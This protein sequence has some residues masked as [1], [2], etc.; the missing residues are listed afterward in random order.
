MV[1]VIREKVDA[2]LLPQ[3]NP[4]KLW[5]GVGS[6]NPCS[7][8]DTPILQSQTEY[9]LL[10]WDDRAPVRFHIGCHGIWQ[11]ARHRIRYERSPR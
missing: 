2:G 11:T 9:E 3:G 1:E 7:A 6:G 5:A 4:L 10:Y 8:C